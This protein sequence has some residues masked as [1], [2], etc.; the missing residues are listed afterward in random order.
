MPLTRRLPKRGFT[1]PFRVESQVVSL[2]DLSRMPEG[3]EVT[4]GV[5]RRKPD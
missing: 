2:D 1:N 5:A 3:I 4:H